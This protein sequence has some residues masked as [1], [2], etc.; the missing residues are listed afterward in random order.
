MSRLVRKG[1]VKTALSW[2]ATKAA[3]LTTGPLGWFVT[4]ILDE[5]WD[6]FG[7][8]IVRYAMIKGA[9]V[10]DKASGT[11]KVHKIRKAKQSGNQDEYDSAVDDAFK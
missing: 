7:D 8:K 11:I 2:I 5:I 3:F 1:V 6:F 4:L 10:Y 9:L